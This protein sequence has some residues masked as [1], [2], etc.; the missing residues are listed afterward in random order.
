MYLVHEADG[1]LVDLAE[2]LY[3]HVRRTVDH[4]FGDLRVIEERI[5]RAVPEYVAGDLIE[6]L[7]PLGS[8]QRHRLL[9]LECPLQHLHHPLSQLGVAHLT[10]VERRAQL[11]YDPEVEPAAQLAEDALPLHADGGVRGLG[12]SHPLRQRSHFDSP[13]SWSP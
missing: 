7:G 5:D 8:G 10:V 9:L 13:S 11:L 1:A 12:G 4:H 6:Q 3:V 2:A